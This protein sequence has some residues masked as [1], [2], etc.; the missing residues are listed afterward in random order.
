MIEVVL[1]TEPTGLSVSEGHR[2]V[3]IGWIALKDLIPTNNKFSSL[4]GIVN[5]ASSALGKRL[6]KERLLNPIY[7]DSILNQRYSFIRILI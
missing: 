6:L 5:N 3:E 2:I 7:D 1:D 4:Y